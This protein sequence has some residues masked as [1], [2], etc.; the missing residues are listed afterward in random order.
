MKEDIGH[1]KILITISSHL[2]LQSSSLHR[3]SILLLQRALLAKTRCYSEKAV[4]NE[5]G[6]F[7]QSIMLLS[8]Y[9][10]SL[11]KFCSSQEGEQRDLQN[12]LLKK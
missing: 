3:K 5:N 9:F 7:S 6:A 12:I 10:L 8:I 1:I 4:I 11:D 2:K